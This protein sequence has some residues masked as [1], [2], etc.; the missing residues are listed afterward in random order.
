MVGKKPVKIERR[1]TRLKAD[2]AD[3]IPFTAASWKIEKRLNISAGPADATLRGLCASG[4]V[5]SVRARYEC[6]S[7]VRGVELRQLVETTPV[8][9]SEWRQVEVDFE[10]DKERPRV[11]VSEADLDH[12]LGQQGSEK[13]PAK[14]KAAQR[15]K[16]QGKVPRHY[17]DG[18]PDPANCPRK[19]LHFRLV[20]D[21]PSLKPLDLAT[22]KK[23]IDE[24]NGNIGND[25]M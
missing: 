9:P 2:I 23:A 17:P 6:L 22:L 19:E 15:G 18:V 20:Q 5:R 12:W 21:D 8:R 3:W 16:A 11:K 13:Q 14:P 7:H 4:E 25:P 10:T 24:Y 1:Q